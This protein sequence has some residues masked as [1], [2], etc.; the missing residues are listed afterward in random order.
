MTV[1]HQATPTPGATFAQ[2]ELLHA[3]QLLNRY[4]RPVHPNAVFHP[5]PG[6]PTGFSLT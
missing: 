3:R 4:Q 5:P 2:Q 6:T 1:A